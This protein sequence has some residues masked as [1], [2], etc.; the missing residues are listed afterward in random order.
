MNLSKSF[1]RLTFCLTLLP[2]AAEIV[3]TDA[4]AQSVAQDQAP[5][6][7]LAPVIHADHI[8]TRS[9]EPIDTLVIC[10]PAFRGV[11][12]PWIALRRQQGHGVEVLGNHGTAAALRGEI[13]Q[14]AERYPL[15]YL[16]LVGDA[17]PDADNPFVR[18]R[19]VPTFRGQASIT[20]AWDDD[21]PTIST[22][23]PY[24]DL[25]GDQTPDLA[26]GRLSADSQQQLQVIID[27]I[28]AYEQMPNTGLWRRRMHFVAGLGG[29]GP[30]A[31]A[32]IEMAA[33]KLI[34]SDIP[35]AYQAT[36][37]F[38]NWRSPFC[39]DPRY[40]RDQVLRRVEEGCLFW[41]YLGHGHKRRLDRFVV[42]DGL[43]PILEAHDVPAVRSTQGLPIA[44]LLACYTGAFN[45]PEDC[46][47]EMLL[48]K[49]EG[50]VGVICG[51]RV[52]MPYSMA[53]LG[54][55]MLS[56]YFG[57]RAPT[58]GDLFLEAKRSLSLPADE[59]DPN[60][61]LLDTIAK[62]LSPSKSD[63]AAERAEHQLLFQLLG[64]PLL[65]L[66]QPQ[67]L[68]VDCKRHAET[69]EPLVVSGNAPF[70]GACLVELVCRR[71]RLTFD[72]SKR[73]KIELSEV[74]LNQ[75]TET[76]LRANDSRWTAKRIDVKPGKFSTQVPV[77]AHAHGSCF[78]R[79]F[80]QG[81]SECAIGDAPIYIAKQQES[82]ASQ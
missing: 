37:T 44:V 8:R 6:E 29:F 19:C 67:T 25:D 45:D 41:V 18:Q 12:E 62:T 53:A 49:K 82:L 33:R 78:V 66:R 14:R 50:P 42:S 61:K 1:A 13:R 80:L 75:M 56:A 30:V 24:A 23:N 81:A 79:V 32:M 64:D 52:T 46:L 11:M 74:E 58:M 21:D 3:I 68:E 60:R 72:H 47:G 26:V 34:G 17:E 39:P 63:L 5:A 54:T 15:K 76:Y 51:S 70:A 9:P 59:L 77:P 73:R 48:R 4:A 36:M 10:P 40:F 20:A 28:L 35:A 71:D 31:D 43:F 57:G 2:F 7:P 22:D 55:G 16:V 27:K 69:G 38:A 65:T